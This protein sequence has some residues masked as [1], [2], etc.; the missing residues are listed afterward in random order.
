MSAQGIVKRLF[1]AGNCF[2][3]R[4]MDPSN[5]PLD[6]LDFASARRTLSASKTPRSSRSVGSGGSL[7]EYRFVSLGVEG[8]RKSTPRSRRGGVSFLRIWLAV[9]MLLRCFDCHRP[10]IF[11]VVLL[12]HPDFSVRLQRVSATSSVTHAKE[13]AVGHYYVPSAPISRRIFVEPSLS[14]SLL[15]RQDIEPCPKGSDLHWSGC[16][17]IAY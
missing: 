7:C 17:S 5:Y 15:F 6:A 10:K 3:L 8:V 13:P 12:G 16:R 11:A 4:P 14:L 9:A 2:S 1:L